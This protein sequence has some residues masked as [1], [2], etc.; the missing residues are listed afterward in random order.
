MTTLLARH[1][2]TQVGDKLADMAD[3]AAIVALAD[4]TIAVDTSV[5]HLAG[6]LGREAW[7][8]L[9]FSPDWRWTLSGEHSPWYPQVRL[10]RQPA[11]GDWPGVVA[12]VRDA[13]LRISTSQ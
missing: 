1:N 9:P 4:I 7:V 12:A 6:A 10:L 5:A 2:I 8:L 3:T 11:P 13:L